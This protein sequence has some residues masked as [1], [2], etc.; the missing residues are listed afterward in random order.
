MRDG[1]PLRQILPFPIPISQEEAMS[2]TLC[3]NERV[4]SSTAESQAEPQRDDSGG[5]DERGRFTAG[6]P[7]GPGNPFARRVAQFRTV[8]HECASLEDMKYIGGQLVA[9]A[10]SGDM[11]ATKL[12][13]QYQVGKPAATVDPDTLD[14][15][16]IALFLRGPTGED[17]HALTS[18]QRIPPAAWMTILRVCL[19]VIVRQFHD[20]FLKMFERTDAAQAAGEPPD[21]DAIVEDA[22]D[23]VLG[24]TAEEEVYQPPVGTYANDDHRA[25]ATAKADENMEDFPC[26]E[27]TEPL[28]N[29]YFHGLHKRQSVSGKGDNE[30]PGTLPPGFERCPLCRR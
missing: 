29:G 17:I 7:G 20:V 28:A 15:Q 26:P 24:R 10:K 13:L 12:L 22:I 18:G 3:G 30:G 11:A 8:L 9:L 14:L 23:E 4:S 16:E 1:A 2:A 25:Q 5:R 27:A 19:P 21:S 6:N